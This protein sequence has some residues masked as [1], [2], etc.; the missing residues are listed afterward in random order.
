LQK[1]SQQQK[2]KE[3]NQF[4]SKKIFVNIVIEQKISIPSYI[5][6]MLNLGANFQLASLPS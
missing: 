5:I 4:W 2:Q 3:K 6:C 1:Q